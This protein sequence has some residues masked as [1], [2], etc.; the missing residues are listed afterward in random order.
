MLAHL[1]RMREENK[2]DVEAV[3]LLD[4]VLNVKWFWV[5]VLG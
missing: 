5:M 1:K 4:K 3:Q 2:F